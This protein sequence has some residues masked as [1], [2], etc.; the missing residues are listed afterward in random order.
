MTNCSH[1]MTPVQLP[2]VPVCSHSS[3]TSTRELGWHCYYC[4][5]QVMS[6]WLPIP[7]AT[8]RAAIAA[9]TQPEQNSGR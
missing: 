3:F 7:L 6:P 4:K 5:V 8:L 2:E 1:P 9:I